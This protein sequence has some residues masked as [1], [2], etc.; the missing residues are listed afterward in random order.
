MKISNKAKTF[1]GGLRGNEGCML[2][3]TDIR[4]QMKGSLASLPLRMH[5]TLMK[6]S[7]CNFQF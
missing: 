6:N 1:A 7:N 3:M 4:K 2:S 5:L